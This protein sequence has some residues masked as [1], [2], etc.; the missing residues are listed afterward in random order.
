VATLDEMMREINR[1]TEETS[2]LTE[3]AR[4]TIE[5]EWHH[6]HSEL[7]PQF[8]GWKE[9]VQGLFFS[10]FYLQKG[11]LAFVP[12][13]S[14]ASSP[15]FAAPITLRGDMA[16]LTDAYGTRSGL[17]V[18]LCMSSHDMQFDFSAKTVL[19]PIVLFE[20]TVGIVAARI[21][22]LAP[23]QY[24]EISRATAVLLDAIRANLFQRVAIGTKR[25][26]GKAS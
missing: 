10:T 22:A 21:P 16:P 5:Q 12:L 7:F 8:C 1:L 14:D 25:N 9:Q 11:A 3:Q 13:L 20:R 23:A 19:F 24:E 6:L 4:Q 18:G 15:Q 17:L 26:M 2:A